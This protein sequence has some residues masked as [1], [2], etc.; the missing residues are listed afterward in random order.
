MVAT[1]TVRC[2]RCHELIGR[3]EKWELDHRDDGRG[4]LGAS[5]QRCNSRA[6]W[7]R[8]VS[9]NGSAGGFE[10]RPYKW[11]QRWFQDPPVG[12]TVNLG[13]GMVEVHVGGGLWQTIAR[14]SLEGE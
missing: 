4:W 12:T 7:E 13:D 9:L 8:M 3:E 6:G 1:G 14:A 2:A 5:H 11:S 10:E